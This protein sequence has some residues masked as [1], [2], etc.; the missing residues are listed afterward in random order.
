VA[1]STHSPGSGMTGCYTLHFS[2]SVIC[3]L[4]GS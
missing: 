1:V 3:L 2:P 4:A